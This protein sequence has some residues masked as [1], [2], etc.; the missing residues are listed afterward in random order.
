MGGH[1][2]SI[3]PASELVN[4]IGTWVSGGPAHAAPRRHRQ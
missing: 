4:R 1:K 3:L 2:D